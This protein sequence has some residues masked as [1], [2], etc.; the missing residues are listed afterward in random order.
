VALESVLA[1]VCVA[2]GLSFIWPQVIR[3]YRVNTV[4][5]LSPYGTLHGLAGGVLW[6]VYGLGRGL[7]TMYVTNLFI[8]VALLMIAA[9][10]VR[11]GVLTPGRVLATIAGTLAV[12]VSTSVV[13]PAITGW[14]AIVV[15]ATSILPQTYHA[16]RTTDLSGVSVAMYGMVIVNT[17]CWTV[18]GLLI[19]DAIIAVPAVLVL[20]CAFLIIS[21]ALQSRG[22]DDGELLLA[23][24]PVA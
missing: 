14:V 19:G 20:P 7:P 8:G 10:Q 1:V 22:Q 3:V 24:C 13:D 21:K 18:Y 23:A 16:L 9:A 15:G 12:A 5:G 6:S 11:H 4:E 17:V 2:L